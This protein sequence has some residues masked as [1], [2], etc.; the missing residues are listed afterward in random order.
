MPRS[1]SQLR[2]RLLSRPRSKRNDKARRDIQGLRAF[3]VAAVIADHL[4]GWP[5]GGFVGVDIFFVLSGFLITGLL[6]REHERTGRISF[7]GFYRRRVKRI[8]PALVLVLAFT[9]VASGSIFSAGRSRATVV[10]AVW[11]LLF[12]GN[13]RFALQ[14]RLLLAGPT[15]LAPPALLVPG[16]EEQFY[17]VWRW[18]LVLERIGSTPTSATSPAPCT[19]GTSR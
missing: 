16:V 2:H 4:V 17:L 3:A 9:V 5:K 10:H 15:R 6:L 1:R 14:S 19:S 11:A 7:S 18:L 12:W 13:W 8:M